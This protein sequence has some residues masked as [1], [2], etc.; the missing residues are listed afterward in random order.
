MF[1]WY[2]ANTNTFREMGNLFGVCKSTAWHVI[3]RVCLWLIS[4]GHR[5]LKWPNSSEALYIAEVFEEKT[6]IPGVL[7]C[8]DGTH[9]AIK[10]PQQNKE[11]YFNRKRFYSISL[12]AVV[13]YRMKFL[14]VYSGEPGSLHDSRVLRRSELYRKAYEDLNSYFF[15]NSFLLGDSAY[16]SLDW[17]VP[18]FRDNGMLSR[19]E[20]RFN[21]LHSKGRV[22]VE[23]AFGL[24]KTRFRRLLHFNE[25]TN[26]N[27]IVNLVTCGCILHNICVDIND[28]IAIELFEEYSENN[29]NNENNR[30]VTNSTR[31]QLLIEELIQRN[32]L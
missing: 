30:M 23:H 7:G 32:V 29:E 24:L 8:I 18:P 11:S 2:M 13:D 3:R 26:I 9:I 21:T 28:T 14:S 17:L 6:K 19:I 1:L 5:Y 20:R 12:Q 22:V 10:A 31:R 27:F 4:I 15:N 16:P 25:L